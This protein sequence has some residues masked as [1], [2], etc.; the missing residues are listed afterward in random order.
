[1]SNTNEMKQSGAIPINKVRRYLNKKLF[2]NKLPARIGALGFD[3]ST[4]FDIR[5]QIGQLTIKNQGDNFS[6]GGQAGAGFIEVQRRRQ[7]ITEGSISAKSI[8]AP[9]SYKGGG[10]TIPALI[11]QLATV[12]ANLEAL[13]PSNDAYG[14]ALPEYLMEET[15][16]VSAV[17]TADAFTRAGYTPYDVPIGANVMDTVATVISQWGAVIFEIVGQNGNQ[18]SWVS[19]MP[20]IPSKLNA[21]PLWYH[22]MYAIGA[23]FINGKKY[24][25][26]VQSEGPTWGDNGIQYISEDY[27][28]SGYV[29]DIFTLIYDTHIAPLPT[30]T[31]WYA[32]MLLFFRSLF[33]VEAPA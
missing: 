14:N 11:K 26:A 6:C 19:D 31:S 18:P 5:N 2:R 32:M 13:V 1:M 8:Y 21:N 22:F 24:I 9:I 16:W 20:S 10:T 33:K 17:T 7:G 4:G 15:S 3:W 25:I 30:N 28:T 12:G 27:F 23:K 29:K